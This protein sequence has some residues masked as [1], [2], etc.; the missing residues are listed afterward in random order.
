MQNRWISCATALLLA[1]AGA[2]AQSLLEHATVAGPAASGSTAGAVVGN[3]IAAALGAA[4]GDVKAAP[5]TTE[6]GPREAVTARRRQA[7]HAARA[8]TNLEPHVIPAKEPPIVWTRDMSVRAEREHAQDVAATVARTA[9]AREPE[10]PAMS[11][12]QFV[13]AI[14]AVQDGWSRSQLV[15]KLGTPLDSISMGDDSGFVERYR[16]GLPAEPLA[17]VVLR[18]GVVESVSKLAQ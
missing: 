7:R 9:P 18:N 1:A 16:F 4:A 6:T 17:L 15:A 2:G 8:N 10:R 5:T 3:R 13:K 11:R 12:A 14:E